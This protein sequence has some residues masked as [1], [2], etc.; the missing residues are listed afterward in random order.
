[1]SNTI[2]EALVI[3]ARKIISKKT[4]EGKKEWMT[5]EILNMM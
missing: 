5:D 3:S 1:M 2:R 4:E